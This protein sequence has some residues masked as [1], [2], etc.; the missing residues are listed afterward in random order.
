M[1]GPMG[2]LLAS[3]SAFAAAT[4]VLSVPAAAAAQDLSPDGPKCG[5]SSGRTFQTATAEQE[6][7][8]SAR[9]ADAMA[10]A[11]GVGRTNIQV[12][13]RGCLIG[14]GPT[15]DQT[16][17]VP[18]NLWSGTKGVVS[19]VAG[20]AYDQGKLDLD[21]PIGTYLPPDFGDAA[22]R[23]IT[24]RDLLTQ[25]SGLV[26]ST[27]MELLTSLGPIDPDVGA[28]AMGIPLATPPGSTFSYS[29]RAVDLLSAVVEAAVGEPLQQF[30]QRQLFDPL[31]I[32]RSDYYWAHD[33]SGH[34]YGFGDLLIPPVDFAKLGLLITDDGFWGDQ[35]V[36]SSDYLHQAHSS[37]PTNHCYGFL[38]WVGPGCAELPT[39]LPA[40]SY[41][42]AGFNMQNIFV[43]P[44]L[45]M[46]V[47]WTG[48][49][50]PTTNEM[51]PWEFW[52]RLY[53]AFDEPPIPDPGPYVDPDP[54]GP[55]RNI[56]S[57]FNFPVLAGAL[58]VGPDSYPGCTPLA[59]RGET[60]AD[61]FTDAPP[62]CILYTCVG[63]DPR[64]PGIR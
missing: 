16:D 54:L 11:V 36:I 3:I 50:G 2:W 23:A 42:L 41:T 8:D 48:G 47:V 34:T 58:G 45:D 53:A 39:F 19:L 22:H 57:N 33:R 40:D 6:G 35:R 52:R 9:M 4:L 21:A 56:A 7:L 37:S 5:V 59:C 26:T 27:T 31:G 32:E 38:L 64:T 55:F 61:P 15:N 25:T 63:D 10:Y 28:E 24:V 13:R 12:F 1:L 46:T 14:R 30:A 44:S 29:G 18:W 17:G 49:I 20:I 43:V 62:G 60:L 51:V